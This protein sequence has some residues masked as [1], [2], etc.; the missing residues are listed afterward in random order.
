MGQHRILV[1]MDFTPV[2]DIALEHA[3]VV[4]KAFQSEILL[5]HIIANKKEMP[6]AR[7]R[8]S[9]LIERHSSAYPHKVQTAI[10]IGSIF[11]DIDDVA[12]EQDATLVI[13][14]THGLKGMQFLTGGRAL[15][16]VTNSSTPFI[17]TQERTIK[18]NGYDDIIVPL[19]LHQD[20]KQKL[21]I[22]AEMAQYFKGRVHIISPGETDEFLK[23][24][25]LR[26]IEYAKEYFGEKG[27][28][29]TVKISEHSASAFVKDVIRY[30]ASIDAD[31]IGIMNLHEKS[32]MGILGHS[33]EQ[34]IVTNEA[35]IPVLVIN[36]IATRVIRGSVFAQ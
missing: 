10:R 22:V 6:E 28:D 24:Q 36:P 16:I 31:L 25:L 1:P 5:L 14:G 34:Q 18:E 11:E 3:F 30:A 26:N 12:V 4:G 15:R 23:N 29:Y 32:L 19:A 7:E 20:T 21:T 2:S 13:M 8:M 17:I 27:I 35:Q 33:Y 9:S